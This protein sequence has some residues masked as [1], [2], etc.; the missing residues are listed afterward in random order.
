MQFIDAEDCVSIDI[1]MV[2]D[3]MEDDV[4]K[5]GKVMFTNADVETNYG[6]MENDKVRPVNDKLDDKIDV[7]VGSV[8]EKNN[9]MVNSDRENYAEDD[10]AG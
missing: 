2:T 10:V 1:M 7:T 6:E 8:A 4:K 9:V 3:I 5:N